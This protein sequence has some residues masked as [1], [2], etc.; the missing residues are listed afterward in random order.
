VSAIFAIHIRGREGKGKSSKPSMFP[1]PF[2]EWFMSVIRILAEKVASQIAAGEVIERPAS[3]VKELM[4]NSIDSGADRI[5]VKIGMG[6]KELIR[7]SDNGC[8]M[9]KDDLLLCLERH[10]TSKIGD[11]NDLFSVRTLGFRG[12]ALPS[13]CAVS[14]MEITSRVAD[15]LI[16]H[17]LKAGGG[18]LKSIDEAG[19]P[20]GTTVEVRK[21]FF[22]TPVRKK[23]LRSERT[24]TDQIIDM[25]SR[26]ALPFTNI[27]FRLDD[28]ENMILNLPA[29][30]NETNRLTALFGRKL[31]ASMIQAEE[32]GDSFKIQAYLSPPEQSR[33]KGDRLLLY[34]NRRNIR[35]RLLAHAVM[36]GY[37]QRLMRGQYPQAIIVIDIDPLLIDIN[38]H[39]TKQE[40]RFHQ[41]RV[42]HQALVATVEKALRSS[43]P[44]IAGTGF[45]SGYDEKEKTP[46]LS[47]MSTAE[48]VQEYLRIPSGEPVFKKEGLWAGEIRVIGQLQDTYL[49]CQAEDGLIIVDQHA[50]HERIV[51]ETL[52]KS[53]RDLKTERQSYLIP[54]KVELSIKEARIID[55]RLHELLTLGLEMEPFG[56]E[57]FILRSVPSILV[58]ANWESFFH[59]MILLLEE[60]TDITRERAMDRL[61]TVMACHGAIRAGQVLSQ[62]EMALLLRQ[63]EQVDLPTNCPHGRPVLKKLSF[64]EIEKMFKRL[65]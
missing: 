20:A 55:Q 14:E 8:G 43:F 56:G 32:G 33:R 47:G 61:L 39:P 36:D 57:T 19:A 60:E 10:A 54:P 17:R 5:S 15:E 59:D 27:H 24:E 40:V 65:I 49:L 35:D 26:I 22:N 34:V 12:E 21:L 50:A 29:S 53:F 18:R 11:L 6:G 2:E 63:L 23:F 41:P 64:Y 62:Q 37:G 16:G 52:K 58:K 45:V 44:P 25:F 13:I 4:D 9:G 31:A 30:E 46:L 42:V 28:A 7:V 38:V 51:Y 3:I 1:C 48:P